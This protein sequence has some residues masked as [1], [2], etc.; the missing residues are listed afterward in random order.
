MA[1]IS[2]HE[3]LCT[4]YQIFLT[5]K[6]NM[7]TQIQHTADE[8]STVLTETIPLDWGGARL[9]QA[10]ARLFSDYSRERLK[11][12]INQGHLLVEGKVW[13][14]KDRVAGGENVTLEI[15][16]EVETEAKPQDIPLN[17]IYEDADI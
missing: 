6:P 3:V 7:T 16:L 11:E 14:P 8:P 15:M 17:I 4:Y 1:R 13:R 2:N 12:W 10:V 9:D 5:V